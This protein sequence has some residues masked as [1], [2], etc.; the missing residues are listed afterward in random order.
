MSIDSL[1]KPKPFSGWRA[2]VGT[3]LTS[4]IEG[5]VYIIILPACPPELRAIYSSTRLSGVYVLAA[6][7]TSSALRP[8]RFTTSPKDS[9]PRGA[10][11][12]SLPEVFAVSSQPV[13]NTIAKL[14]KKA[15][16]RWSEIIFIFFISI[17]Y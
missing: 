13:A 16:N 1:L 15:N 17:L 8:L 4:L 11:K 9:S 5:M 10:P 12:S 2:A 3:Y 14:S 7:R 6:A